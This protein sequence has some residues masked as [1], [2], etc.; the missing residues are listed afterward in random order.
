LRDLNSFYEKHPPGTQLSK[1]GI[2]LLEDGTPL[3]D[4]S[5]EFNPNEE[6]DLDKYE[7]IPYLTKGLL[8]NALAGLA[9]SGGNLVSALGVLDTESMANQTSIYKI[10]RTPEQDD[11]PANFNIHPKRMAF[12]ISTILKGRLYD[13]V[14]NGPGSQL[15][16]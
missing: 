2:P 11:L 5:E 1:K 8:Y 16:V 9:T 7:I 15:K 12:V 6:F 3:L 13:S 10:I 4:L 14:Q